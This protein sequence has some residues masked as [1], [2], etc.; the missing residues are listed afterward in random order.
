MSRRTNESL[1]DHT[2]GADD[3]DATETAIGCSLVTP[4][5]TVICIIAA[6]AMGWVDLN[7]WNLG[8]F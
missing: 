1:L 5:L 2:A 3:D 7:I 8:G 6:E 4:V